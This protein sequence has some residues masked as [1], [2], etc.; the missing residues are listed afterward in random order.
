M[1]TYI[2]TSP[3]KRDGKKLAAGQRVELSDAEAEELIGLEAI[4][5]NPVEVA[6]PGAGSA[7]RLASIVAAIGKLDQADTSLWT[8]S[9]LPKTEVLAAATGG[10]VSAAERDAAWAEFGKA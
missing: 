1:K 7:T 9:G 3:I 5:P 2:T 4:H 6:S 8:G 10:P